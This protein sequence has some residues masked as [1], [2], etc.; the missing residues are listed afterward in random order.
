VASR[1]DILDALEEALRLHGEVVVPAAG[2]SMD[3]VFREAEGLV[4]HALCDESVRRGDVV[5]IRREGLWVVHRVVLCWGRGSRRTV[6]TKGDAVRTIDR[7]FSGPDDI[8]GRVV[9]ARTPAGVVDLAGDA[10]RR[11]GRRI[12]M[13]SLAKGLL[14]GAAMLRGQAR[15]RPTS[16]DR[17]PPSG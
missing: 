15:R 10:A 11:A 2:V 7:P 17:R 13:R 12:A 1:N 8:V 9:A 4:V 16:C 6:V 5:V 3:G 14:A